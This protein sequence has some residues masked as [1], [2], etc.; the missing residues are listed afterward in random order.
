MSVIVR[1]LGESGISLRCSVLTHTPE[2]NYQACSDLRLAL[3]RRFQEEDGLEFAY[4]HMQILEETEAGQK[5]EAC[6]VL[7]S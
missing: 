1:D 3:W 6:D 7:S 4:P 5:K 2:E